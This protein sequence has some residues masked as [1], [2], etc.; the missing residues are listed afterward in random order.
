MNYAI[1]ME[2][3]ATGTIL[4]VALQ[5]AWHRPH[6]YDLFDRALVV[7]HGS[8][9]VV[10]LLFGLAIWLLRPE[11]MRRYAAAMVLLMYA[12]L[13]VY[14]LVPTVP[15][16]MAAES[17]GVIPPVHR[18]AGTIYNVTIPAM[19]GAF[20]TNPVAAMPSLHA[21]FPTL[22]T[23]IGLTVFGLRA[24]PL[25]AYTLAVFLAITYLG[26]HYLVDVVAGALMAGGAYVVVYR[27]GMLFRWRT[28]ERASPAV[29]ALVLIVIA[30]GI[31]YAT[32]AIRRPWVVTEEFARR[33]LVGRSDKAHYYLGRVAYR[34]GDYRTAAT[35]FLRAARVPEQSRERDVDLWV[36][37]SAYRS[38][39]YAL[40]MATLENDAAGRSLEHGILLALS[41]AASNR[42]DAAIPV[43]Q[44]LTARMPA[45]PE[46]LYWL[47]ALQFRQ[48]TISAAKVI[49]VAGRMSGL[50]NAACAERLQRSLLDLAREQ[51]PQTISLSDG[52]ALPDIRSAL[53]PPCAAAR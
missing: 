49:E 47:T 16:W 41:Y 4:P 28:V 52:S 27:W 53:R 6:S 15:P 1:A 34:E 3:F 18:I 31:G 33:E 50:P 46:P 24:T 21:A 35:E 40:V 11:E 45:Q 43:L 44:D 26:E 17:F 8:H 7:V 9:F 48:G 22:C 29:V 32:E 14:L 42:M 37:Q 39:D 2:R 38:Q 10:F 30:Q 5:D 12:G 25:I 23:L 20:D 19:Q 51:A 13:A 36:A